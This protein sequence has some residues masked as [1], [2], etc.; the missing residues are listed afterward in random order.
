MVMGSN[1]QIKNIENINETIVE[2]KKSFQDTTDILTEVI[3][4]IKR[5]SG[6]VNVNRGLLLDTIFLKMKLNNE[7]NS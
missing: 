5:D 4:H 3:D 2:K 1:V 7:I 6:I